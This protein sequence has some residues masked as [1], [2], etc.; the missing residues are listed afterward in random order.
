MIVP[1]NETNVGLN[2]I[3]GERTLDRLIDVTPCFSSTDSWNPDHRRGTGEI[4]L[5]PEN[6][7]ARFWKSGYGCA[8]GRGA[9]ER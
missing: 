8:A 5:S 7:A 3:F 2:D 6:W 4:A 1:T 9:E